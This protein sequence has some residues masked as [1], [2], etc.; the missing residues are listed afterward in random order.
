MHYD[1]NLFIIWSIRC[2][3]NRTRIGCGFRLLG[4]WFSLSVKGYNLNYM[5]MNSIIPLPIF[6]ALAHAHT[7]THT[8]W[9]VNGNILRS[10]QKLKT[11]LASKFAFERHVKMCIIFWHCL[12]LIKHVEKSHAEKFGSTPHNELNKN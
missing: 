6:H 9:I 4:Y 11:R 10:V 12:A 2:W 7:H 3:P 8:V 1:K 5:Y